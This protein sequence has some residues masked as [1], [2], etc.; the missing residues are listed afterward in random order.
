MG[1]SS[2]LL[3]QAGFVKRKIAIAIAIEW[4][5]ELDGLGQQW[6]LSSRIA[7]DEG[8]YFEID[9]IAGEFL[10]SLGA[11]KRF[12]G[13]DDNYGVNVTTSSIAWE[14]S[15]VGTV[16]TLNGENI[17]TSSDIPQ[18]SLARTLKV[19]PTQST[20]IQ[21][22]GG[23]STVGNRSVNAAIF[24]FRHYNSDGFLIHEIPLTSKEQGATQ[25]AT[26]GNINAFMTNYTKAVW[27]D[28]AKL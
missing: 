17:I 1:I 13:S 5:A 2:P 7:T 10:G 11:Y 24:N 27:K 25:L 6:N 3:K 23:L 22:I 28:R 16:A 20:T 21:S 26:V 12:L 15:V 19:T 18:D 14:F 8:D 4:V 9:Y